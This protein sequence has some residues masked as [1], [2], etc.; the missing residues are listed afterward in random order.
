[1]LNRKIKNIIYTAVFAAIVFV[2]IRFL[3]IA[4]GGGYYHIGDAFIYLA[5]VCLPFPY[6]SIAGALGGSLA[7]LTSPA[8]VFALPTFII[9]ACVAGCFTNKTAKILCVRNITAILAASVITIAGYGITYI[10]L[11]GW[12]GLANSYGDFAQVILNAVIFAAMGAAFDKINLRRRLF[13]E[14]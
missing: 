14:L 6:A 12:G 11:F 13:Y 3:G 4:A 5:G 8:A 10:I 9:K 7:N 1:V 2:A